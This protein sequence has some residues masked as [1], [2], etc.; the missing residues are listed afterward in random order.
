MG[1]SSPDVSF[2][3]SRW[4]EV[5]VLTLASQDYELHRVIHELHKEIHELS[6]VIYDLLRVIHELH[7][8]ILNSIQFFTN[9]GACESI[10]MPFPL[11]RSWRPRRA[12]P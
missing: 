1:C 8:V 5:V 12:W 3:L 10:N 9:S 6:T 4:R 7:R 2:H 11:V